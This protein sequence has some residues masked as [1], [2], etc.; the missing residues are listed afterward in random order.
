MFTHKT[1][2]GGSSNI[3]YY[4]RG[5]SGPGLEKSENSSEITKC[6][7]KAEKKSTIY[8]EKFANKIFNAM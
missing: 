1:L 4:Q 8:P 2:K 3:P 5:I 7:K 6:A